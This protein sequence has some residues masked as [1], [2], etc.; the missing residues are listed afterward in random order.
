M[1]ETV[2]AGKTGTGNTIE[3][4]PITEGG[5]TKAILTN[6]VLDITTIRSAER[7]YWEVKV[8]KGQGGR[9]TLVEIDM[10]GIR[11]TMSIVLQDGGENI[12]VRVA[13][14]ALHSSCSRSC[15]W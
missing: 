10:T 7:V 2:E 13:V 11:A 15:D 6:S 9:A 1:P 3:T 4:D 14:Y 5:V 8:G 12:E